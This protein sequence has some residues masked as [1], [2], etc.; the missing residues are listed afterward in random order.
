MPHAVSFGLEVAHVVLVR[1]NFDGYI[2]YDFESVCF[3]SYTFH[4]VVGEQAHLM[5]AEV[6]EHLCAAAV[7]ALIWLEA[8][9]NIGVY[10]VVSFFLQLVGGNLVHQSDASAFLLHVDDD[11]LACFLNLFH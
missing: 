5:Y 1:F 11:S 6:A 3:Q 8:E 4:R 10:G 9:V 7:V 2:L